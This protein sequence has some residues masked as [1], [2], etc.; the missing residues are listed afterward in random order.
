M[1]SLN[2][3]RNAVEELCVIIA[4]ELKQWNTIQEVADYLRLSRRT[5][6]R[7]IRAGALQAKKD[8]GLTRIKKEWVL[9]YETADLL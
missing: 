3:M 4:G 6:E 5:V 2:K 7:R 8:G 1:I 9:T